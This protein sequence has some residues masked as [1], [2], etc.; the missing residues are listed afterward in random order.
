MKL[1]KT[2][3]A[4][5]TAATFA[6]TAASAIS[7]DQ[8]NELGGAV[9]LASATCTLTAAQE[10]RARALGYLPGGATATT[11]AGLGGTAVSTGTIAAV[12]GGLILAVVLI[13]DDDSSGS[14]TTTT[15]TS[16]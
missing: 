7:V 9:D 10:E 4:V 5:A 15:G 2:F 3:I 1:S 6:A 13:G 11:T 16:D 12:A 8:C 14:T